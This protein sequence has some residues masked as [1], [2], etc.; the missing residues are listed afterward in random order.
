MSSFKEAKVCLCI[1]AIIMLLSTLFYFVATMVTSMGYKGLKTDENLNAAETYSSCLPMIIID[2]G[3][4]GEDC[5]ATSD[6][7]IEKDLNLAI[8]FKLRDVFKAFGYEV[9]LT[10]IDDTMLY[11]DGEEHR[12]KFHD[13]QN[14]VLFANTYSDAVFI[15]VHMNKFPASYCKGLQTFYS[16]NNSKSKQIAETIQQSAR[17]LQQ[18]NNRKIKSGQDTIYILNKLQM[19]AVLV[20][21]GF[22]SNN[23]DAKLLSDDEYQKLLAFSIYCGVAEGMEN[24][25]S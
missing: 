16:E 24:K 11:R 23:E 22:L 20:E 19:P 6:G 25:V 2:P 13:L 8:S 17:L 21:C 5:G 10:R 12:K 15:S 3:H 9:V 4:G 7:Y 18:D 14:R 1:V